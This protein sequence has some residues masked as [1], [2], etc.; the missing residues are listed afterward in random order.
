MLMQGVFNIYIVFCVLSNSI[1]RPQS[2]KV[3]RNMGDL[4]SPIKWVTTPLGKYPHQTISEINHLGE[5]SITFNLCYDTADW[6]SQGTCQDSRK[7]GITNQKFLPPNLL[8][9]LVLT[10]ASHFTKNSVPSFSFTRCHMHLN[11]LWD[12]LTWDWNGCPQELGWDQWQFCHCQHS[13]PSDL[14][15]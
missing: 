7:N 2:S 1:L 15:S 3:L 14:G 10:S 8:L 4:S 9:S 5:I 12:T 6:F 13:Y 11:F